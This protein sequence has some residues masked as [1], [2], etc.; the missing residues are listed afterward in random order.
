MPR[1][2]KFCHFLHSAFGKLYTFLQITVLFIFGLT[3]SE[4]NEGFK[5]VGKGKT[6]TLVEYFDFSCPLSA[7]SSKSLASFKDKMG[8]R[9][10][11]VRKSLAFSEGGL[12]WIAGKYYHALLKQNKKLAEPFYKK[13]FEQTL[14]GEINEAF[15]KNV[16]TNLGID[17][18]K[19][20]SGLKSPF[21]EKQLQQNEVL[22]NKSG[23]FVSPGYT[24][25][26]Q[27]LLGKQESTDF[28]KLFSQR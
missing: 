17:F 21:L 15:L 8:S 25:D 14:K 9:V 2:R 23:I 4:A 22:A 5:R 24:L 13:V 7:Q 1:L 11:V 3:L 18:A 27:V 26:G 10:Q 12:S 6:L 20:Q 19:F 16:I 28:G